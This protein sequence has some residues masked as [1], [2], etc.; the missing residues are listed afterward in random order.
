MSNEVSQF[1]NVL[2]SKPDTGNI[3]GAGEVGEKFCVCPIA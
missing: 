3:S 2:E 1:T